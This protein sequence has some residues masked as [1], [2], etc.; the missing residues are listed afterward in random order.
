MRK[1]PPFLCGFTRFFCLFY[2]YVVFIVGVGAGVIAAVVFH[3]VACVVLCNTRYCS[4]TP[5]VV[6]H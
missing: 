5:G 4:N 2:L 1:P 6:L 3:A